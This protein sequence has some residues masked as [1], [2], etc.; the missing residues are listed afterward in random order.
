MSDKKINKKVFFQMVA[1][2]ALSLPAFAQGGMPPG[3]PGGGPGGMHGAGPGFGPG[4]GSTPGMFGGMGMGHGKVITSAPYSA[5]L[6]NTM[7]Q[8]L[9]DGNTITR[10]TTGQVARDSDGRTFEQVTITGG[11]MSGPGTKSLTFISDPVAGYSYV[12]DS[13]NKTAV[14]RPFHAKTGAGSM[15]PGGPNASGDATRPQRPN[16][17]EATLPADSSSGVI[18]EGKTITRTIPA[19]TMGNAQQIVSTDQV[20]YSS[21]LQIVVKSVRSDPFFGEST[22]ALTNIVSKEPDASLF[23]VPAGYTVTT[24]TG[25]QSWHGR[26]QRPSPAN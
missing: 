16:T 26:G 18:A 15:G 9:A 1:A 4:F 20:W 13:A 24:A 19:N 25:P 2:I 23:K 5:T 7:L 22:Y 3:P 17:T 8:H 14:Q 11:A 12:L 10:S 6:S 21:D